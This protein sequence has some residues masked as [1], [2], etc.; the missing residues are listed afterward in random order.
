MMLDESS[1]FQFR[2]STN[3][4]SGAGVALRLGEEAKS[5]GFSRV[6]V[7]VDSAVADQVYVKKVLDSISFSGLHAEIHQ[8]RA[9]EPSYNDLEL[10]KNF[11][12]GK[13]CHAI[14]GIGGGSTL[15][16]AKGLA[17]LL[18]N[19]GPAL[20]FRGFPNLK[21][22][23]VAVLALPTT[24]GTGSE[25]TFNAVFTDTNEKKKLGIN[26]TS[27]F[28][29]A[30]FLD[31]LLTSECPL[32]VSISSGADAMVHALESF[33]HRRHTPL[34]RL[35]SISAFALLFDNL[36][37]L[38]TGLKDLNVRSNLQLGAYEAAVALMNSGSG[39]SGAL[40]YPLGVHHKV[41]HGLAGAIF[42]PCITR[43]N[44]QAGYLDYA[45][46]YDTIPGSNPS[47]SKGE[48]S[49]QFVVALE[50]LWTKLGIPRRLSEFGLTRPD[51]EALGGHYNF[52]KAA[53]AQNPI[54]LS[55]G[56]VRTMLKELE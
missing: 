1:M 47:L 33:V 36:T 15:D 30:A 11:F 17:V 4:F 19:D 21:N 13:D 54:D 46:L 8:N 22:R 31:P 6:A 25:V 41:P 28:P 10:L 55:E 45:I 53:I 42:L 24:A 56:E 18:R 20:S 2:L 52:L 49:I 38:P 39:P 40:S 34:S 3:I 51:V 29:V 9:V 5:L 32:A 35:F 14:I 48:K 43:F 16:L 23:P 26:S 50:G 27:N 44:V 7:V 37:K 12:E